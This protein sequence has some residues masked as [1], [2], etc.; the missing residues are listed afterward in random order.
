MVNHQKRVI[1][2]ATSDEQLVGFDVCMLL[3]YFGVRLY[4]D[5]VKRSNLGWDVVSR[6]DFAWHAVCEE[7]KRVNKD[8]DNSEGYY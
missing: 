3:L 4:Q 7:G 2:T 1:K 6:H 5:L 8:E